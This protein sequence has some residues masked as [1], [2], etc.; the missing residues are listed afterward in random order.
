MEEGKKVPARAKGGLAR[1]AAM[2]PQDRAESA[3][4]AADARWARDLPRA[5]HEGDANI[6]GVIIPAANL[7]DGRRL[8]SQGRFLQAIGRSRTPKAGTGAHATVDGLP[9]FLQAEALKSFI[10]N[11]LTVST[12]PVFYLSK[13]GRKSVGYDAL[14][15]PNVVNVYLDFRT[16][17]LADGKGIPSQ[18]AHIIAACDALSRGLQRIGIIGI[19][20]EATGFQ[21]VRDKQALQAI[22]DQYL[23]KELATWAKRFPDE[24]YEHIFRLRNW[25]WKGRGTNPPQAV[26]GYTK[27]IVYAR[28]APGILD[29]LEKKNP[30]ESGSRKAKHHQWLT[31]DVG[32]PALTQHLYAV[33]RLMR[34][35]SSWDEFKLFL[36][37]FHPKRGDT[38]MLPLMMEVSY[39]PQPIETLP[40]FERSPGAALAS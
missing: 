36:D 15:L 8:L 3:K 10:P 37:K 1:A 35:C 17:Q 16:A 21:E 24:F 30:V 23:R 29:E 2:S 39:P 5:T 27:D 20:D 7:P 9:F 19:I 13:T 22:L 11:N 26:A 6:G 40:L 12:A 33:I 32:H 28:L 34:G 25:T 14:L 18:Y 4:R 38:L 31:D